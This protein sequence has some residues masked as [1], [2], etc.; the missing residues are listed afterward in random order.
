MIIS[1][2]GNQVGLLDLD[3]CGPSIPRLMGIEGKQVINAS[4]GWLPIKYV[5]NIR[6][7]V[8]LI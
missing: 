2:D 7:I 3:I 4:Y 5:F 6:V 1:N 8:I